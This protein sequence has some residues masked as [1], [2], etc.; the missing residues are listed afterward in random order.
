MCKVQIRGYDLSMDLRS[1]Q[2]I[3][4]RRKGGKAFVEVLMRN[5][6]TPKRYVMASYE[7]AIE[8][9]KIVW[10]LRQQALASPED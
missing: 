10:K 8:F 5:E 4:I 7:D 9:Y 6:E 2:Q 3:D 1:I